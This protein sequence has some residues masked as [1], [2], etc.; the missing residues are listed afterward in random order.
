VVSLIFEFGHFRSAGS[1][2]LSRPNWTHLQGGLTF[3]CV[4]HHWCTMS[5]FWSLKR[6]GFHR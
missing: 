1:P 5:H 2:E 3:C 6:K 4:M